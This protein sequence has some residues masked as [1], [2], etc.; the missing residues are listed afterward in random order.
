MWEPRGL[1]GLR[2]QVSELFPYAQDVLNTGGVL[3][4]PRKK[5]WEVA[6]FCTS[7]HRPGLRRE[8]FPPRFTAPKCRSRRW[9]SGKRHQPPWVR[10]WVCW[11][12]SDHP[13]LRTSRGKLRD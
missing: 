8:R 1:S 12:M 13:I 4:G 6:A 7:E 5:R 10:R 3:I 11:E 2:F 9:N